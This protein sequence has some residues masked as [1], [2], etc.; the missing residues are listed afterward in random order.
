MNV[1]GADVTADGENLSAR[2]GFLIRRLHQVHDAL[3]A[4]ECAG[5]DISPVQHS[6]MAA[7]GQRPGADQSQIAADVAV[8]RATLTNMLARLEEAG[9]V[10]RITSRLDR[11]QKLL[12]LTPMGKSLLL[13][14]QDAVLRAHART[15]API[16]AGEQAQF[17]ALLARLVEAGNEPRLRR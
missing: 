4:E 14:M 10:S 3:F 2:P 5:F 6:I 8:D 13:R 1:S 7:I 15:I 12:S 11:R 9:I 16:S 17:M